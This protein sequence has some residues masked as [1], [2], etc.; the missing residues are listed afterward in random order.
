MISCG[1]KFETTTLIK[2]SAGALIEPGTPSMVLGMI[3]R[4]APELYVCET[5][6]N[7]EEFY[8]YAEQI[9]REGQVS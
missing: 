9:R 3:R 6:E 5:L 8:C 2:N 7:V 4:S 1:T